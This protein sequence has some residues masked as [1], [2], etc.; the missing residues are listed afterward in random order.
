MMLEKDVFYVPT[1]N[2]TQG[3]K[4]TRKSGMPEFMLEKISGSAKTHLEGFQKALK[5]GVK[6]ACG[7][8]VTPVSD[9]T[10]LEIGHLVKAGMTEM[11]ALIAATRK[12]ADLCG[13]VDQLGTVEEGKLADL[14]VV[15]ANP[16]E[17]ISTLRN[18][19]LVMKDGK[20]V[21]TREPEGLVDWDEL[22]S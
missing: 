11:E 10:H 8:D 22:Y 9:F 16:L 14:I 6:I 12:S 17:D 3:E 19:K 4:L 1:L 15:S 5:A 21:E 20:L 2:V 18:L 13:V 7:A